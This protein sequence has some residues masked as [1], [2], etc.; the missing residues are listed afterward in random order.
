V[1][2]SHIIQ[3]NDPSD[4]SIPPLSREQLWRG[5]VT[6]AERP[7]YF[8][9]GMDECQI[10]DR[11]ADTLQRQL[12]YGSLL[13]RDRVTFEPPVQVRYDIDTSEEVP[14]GSLVMRIEE[15]QS[16]QLFV[17]FDYELRVEGGTVNDYYNEFRKAAYVESDIDTVRMI[18]QLAASGLLDEQYLA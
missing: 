9:I 10:L 3:I 7:S 11:S 13:V 8:I 14:G 2:F 4:P 5:L 16:Q 6:R 17:R 1:Q 18:R 15:P 12:R